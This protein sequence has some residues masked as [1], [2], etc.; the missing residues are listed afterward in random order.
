V[1]KTKPNTNQATCQKD[2]VGNSAVQEDHGMVP[3]MPSHICSLDQ[4]RLI[5]V[6]DSFNVNVVV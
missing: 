3:L 1:T 6:V 4:F 2:P 5:A